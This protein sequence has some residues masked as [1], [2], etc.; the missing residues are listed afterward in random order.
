MTRITASE[1]QFGTLL[2]RYGQMPI[3]GTPNQQHCSYSILSYNRIH[4]SPGR[5]AAGRRLCAPVQVPP[6]GQCRRPRCL[7]RPQQPMLIAPAARRSVH[8]SPKRASKLRSAC[9]RPKQA[10]SPKHPLKPKTCNFPRIKARRARRGP[11]H[12]WK[13][14]ERIKARS[15]RQ[16]WKRSST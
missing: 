2:Q 13:P 4:C 11:K 7:R 1:V 5:A 15:A 6:C 8:G 12:A 10:R 16:S 14:E 9:R 3:F